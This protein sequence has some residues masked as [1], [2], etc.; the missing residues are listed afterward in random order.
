MYLSAHE[1]NPSSTV[2]P[3]SLK[4]PPGKFRVI[5]T[6][7]IDIWVALDTDDPVLALDYVSKKRQN[8]PY[9]RAYDEGGNRLSPICEL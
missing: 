1:L 3:C 4:A 8:A 9:M 6:D 5:A 7:R 2:S